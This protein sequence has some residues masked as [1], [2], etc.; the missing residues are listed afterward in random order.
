MRSE[1]MDGSPGCAWRSAVDGPK[2]NAFCEEN[3]N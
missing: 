2:D 3:G 1:E